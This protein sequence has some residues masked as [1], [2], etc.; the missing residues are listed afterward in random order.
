[1]EPA[2]LETLSYLDTFHKQMLCQRQDNKNTL[3]ELLCPDCFKK[4]DML[5][6]M[7]KRK[8]K[9]RVIATR[10]YDEKRRLWG[11]SPP[12]HVVCFDYFLSWDYITL[13]FYGK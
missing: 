7:I 12:T 5:F 2:P 1:M 10:L 11:A 6:Y 8:G 13:T 4:G 9:K 3:Y